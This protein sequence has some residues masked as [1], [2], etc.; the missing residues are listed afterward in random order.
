M[1]VTRALARVTIILPSELDEESSS[2]LALL[3]ARCATSLA[4][5]L[6]STTLTTSLLVLLLLLCHLY[7]KVL[8][9]IFQPAK[10]KSQIGRPFSDIRLPRIGVRLPF[11]VI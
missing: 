3:P 10:K 9:F 11:F 6:G 5:P 7:I 2:L 4:S 8:D 1:I